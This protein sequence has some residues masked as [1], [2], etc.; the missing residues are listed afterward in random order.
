MQRRTMFLFVPAGVPPCL[1][2][3]RRSTCCMCTDRGLAAD[4]SP[5]VTSRREV[6]HAASAMALAAAVGATNLLPRAAQAAVFVDTEKYGD[7]EMKVSEINRIKQGFRNLLSEGP[8]LLASVM[9]L[10]IH[11]S[12]TYSKTTGN[13]GPNGSLAYELDLAYNANVKEA[14]EAVDSIRARVK[15]ASV[16][17]LYAFGGAVVSEIVGGPRIVIQL[18]REDVKQAD[19]VEAGD[20]D[21]L[22]SGAS[23]PQIKY[24]F[25]KSG[26]NA[27]ASAVV[28]HGAYGV[29]QSIGQ[30]NAEAKKSMA[31]GDDDEDAAYEEGDLTYGKV[32]KKTRGAVLVETNVATLKLPGTKFDNSYL[33]ELLALKKKGDLSELSARDKAML[34]DPEL[35]AELQKYAAN[36]KLFVNDFADLY[37]KCTMLGVKYESAGAT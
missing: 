33:K 31:G 19:P 10:A 27:A 34:D 4:P 3:Y 16:A 5:P 2:S 14:A 6:L 35:F 21:G 28:Y 18:G 37:E 20:M 13:G 25:A 11:D 17:D 24:T 8:E 29:L 15:D 9:A 1:P 26:L 30:K 32:T 36:S 7:K 12:L 23:A 22:G